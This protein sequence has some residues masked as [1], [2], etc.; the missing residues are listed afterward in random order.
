MLQAADHQATDVRVVRAGLLRPKVDQT[1]LVGA[2]SDLAV[3][4]GPTVG[5]HLSFQRRADLV[6]GLR[7]ELE[8]DQVLG[9]RAQAPA[10]VVTGDDEIA[11]VFRHAHNVRLPL[12]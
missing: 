6:L 7:A 5:L 4:P 1:R 12:R 10:D 3:E 2:P 9:A 8:R 11:A